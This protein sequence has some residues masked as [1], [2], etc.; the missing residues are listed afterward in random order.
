MRGHAGP[1]EVSA[2]G[3]GPTRRCSQGT[4]GRARRRCQV[5]GSA[6]R[7]RRVATPRRLDNR[8]AGVTGSSRGIG[9]AMA[10]R[11]AAEGAAVVFFFN[12]TATT[13]KLPGSIH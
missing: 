1:L 12:E 9:R 11:L 5:G 7:L 4:G 3:S 10:M 6:D 13:E 8:V 2:V